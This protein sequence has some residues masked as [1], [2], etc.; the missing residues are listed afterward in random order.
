M[1]ARMVN[2]AKLGRELPG[3]DEST[4]EGSQ[5]LRM[6]LLL[7]G[8][9]LR[10]RVR[11]QISAEGWREWKDHMMRVV[12]EFRLDATSDGSNEILR[13]QMEDFFFGAGAYV[14]NYVPVDKK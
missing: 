9:A 10:D 11:D 6:C 13:A 7:G 8:P 4:P 1:A 5:A 3:I 2:C 14:P 12:N